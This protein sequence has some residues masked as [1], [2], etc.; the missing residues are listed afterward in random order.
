MKN[1]NA[2]EAYLLEWPPWQTW[3]APIAGKQV[4]IGLGSAP[5]KIQ[6]YKESLSNIDHWH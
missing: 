2:P 1:G 5:S 3:H 6:R 4:E